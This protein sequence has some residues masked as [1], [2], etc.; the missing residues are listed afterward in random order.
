VAVALSVVAAASLRVIVGQPHSVAGSRGAG[1]W[2]ACID[3][4]DAGTVVVNP[5]PIV[6]GL[7]LIVTVTVVPE[8]VA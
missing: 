1:H 3:K 7:K 2:F 5:V 6:P 8:V 4:A